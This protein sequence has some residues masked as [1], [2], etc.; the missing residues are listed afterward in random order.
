MQEQDAQEFICP[1]I[2]SNCITRKCMFWISTSDG[3]KEVDRL[4]EPY[5]MTPMNVSYW[6]ENRLKEGYINVG[7]DNGLR[8]VY[9][10]YIE[11]YEGF[12][13]LRGE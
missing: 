9:I 7:R 12:C 13:K 5:D 4:V 11:S 1:Y 10:K 6:C 8:D 2:N 3:N